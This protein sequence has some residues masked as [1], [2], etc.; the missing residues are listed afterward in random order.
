MSAFNISD[1]TTK[2]SNMLWS[3]DKQKLLLQGEI[4]LETRSHTTWGGAVTAWMYLPLVRS[5]VWQQITDYP[6]WVQYFPDITK[7]EIT[8]K[9]DG[10]F[11]YQA[12]QKAFLFFTAQVEIYLNVVEVI[13]QQIQFKMEKG[14]FE[15]FHAN[16]D[17]KDWGNGTLIAYS[18]QATPHIPIPS[19]FIQ[20]AMSLELPINMR[21]MRQVLCNNQ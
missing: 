3:Q 6:R 7:S 14:S 11:L 15:D 16:L 17:L 5:N 4:L 2:G 9:G 20:Q 12:A 10:K 18:V 13:G 21:K 8:S 19:I 1:S